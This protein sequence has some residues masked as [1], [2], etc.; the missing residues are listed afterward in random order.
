[1]ARDSIDLLV[2]ANASQFN[3]ELSGANKTLDR[4]GNKV[5][6]TDKA[7]KGAFKGGFGGELKKS[8]SGLFKSGG[9]LQTLMAGGLPTASLAAAGGFGAL[10]AAAVAATGALVALGLA[11]FDVLDSLAKEADILNITTKSLASL[12]HAAEATGSSASTMD[13]SLE[14]LSK[15]A[16]LATEGTGAAKRALADLGIEAKDLAK[17]SVDKQF[18]KIAAAIRK[19]ENPS[20]RMA[21][22]SEILGDES[23]NLL[24]LIMEGE[25]GLKTYREEAERLGIAVDRN[26][27]ERV[28]RANDAWDRMKKSVKG[29]GNSVAV[30]IAPAVEWIGN[31]LTD[32]VVAARQQ[33]EFWMPVIKEIGNLFIDQYIAIYEFGKAAVD[34]VSPLFATLK[35]MIDEITGAIDNQKRS[36][37][38]WRDEFI[39]VLTAAGYAVTSVGKQIDILGT[40]VALVFVKIYED[41][42]HLF[43]NIP[44][45]FSTFYEGTKTL[46]T[47]LGTNIANGMQHIWDVLKGQAEGAAPWEPL[48][49]GYKEMFESL[50]REDTKLETDL[51]ARLKTQVE[52][53]QQGFR[54]T[55]SE[56]FMDLNKAAKDTGGAAGKDWADEFGKESSKAARALTP[57]A[58]SRGTQQAFDVIYNANKA[59][60]VDPAVDELKESNDH[61]TEIK[62]LIENNGLAVA[63]L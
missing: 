6:S 57:N 29:L 11:Q 4:F 34:S 13:K 23:R 41:I 26:L 38:E 54:D 10:A 1:M 39:M 59:T 18:E 58:V 16:Y 50:K 43:T 17:L 36:N 44:E 35:E 3:R 30:E 22:A 24:T 19:V 51:K 8:F 60:E 61:L 48:T 7:S 37:K 53:L 32:A 55:M 15:R 28:V 5:R 49:E 63:A 20:K 42:K 12:R 47:N 27:I 52:E 2:R 9:N 45:I 46:F 14:R 25:E 56:K 40:A 21:L 62:T 31:K 33:F